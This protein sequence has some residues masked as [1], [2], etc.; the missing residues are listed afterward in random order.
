MTRDPA[1]PPVHPGAILR[2]D[3][4]PALRL[5]VAEAAKTL[6]VSRQM[7]HRVLQ[8]HAA[9]TPETAVRIGKL[10]GNGPRLWL[11]MQRTFDLWHAERDLAEQVTRIPTLHP[12]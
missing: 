5:S 11:D 2:E 4:L 12:A 9:I 7:L 10:C 8:E 3:V 1:R 6:G